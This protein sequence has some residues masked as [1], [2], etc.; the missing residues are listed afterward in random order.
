[1]KDEEPNPDAAR[2]CGCGRLWRELEQELHG[3]LKARAGVD[4]VWVL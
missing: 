4:S 2:W 3:A 1:M